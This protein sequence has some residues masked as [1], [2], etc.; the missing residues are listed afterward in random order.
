MATNDKSLHDEGLAAPDME[1]Q[2][3]FW[4]EWDVSAREGRPLN[5]ESKRRRDVVLQALRQLALISPRI[6]EVGCANGWMS[7]DLAKFGRVVATDLA[8]EAIAIAAK[9]Y[10]DIEFVTGDFQ[11]LDLGGD[12]DAV[13]CLETLSS[14]AD[15]PRFVGCLAD[16]LKP[17]GYLL[18]TTHNA[19]VYRRRTDVKPHGQGQVRKWTTR[20]ELKELFKPHFRI[21]S[22]RTVIPAGSV[23]ILRFVNS[24]KLTAL[25][26][27]IIGKQRTNSLKEAC[28]FGT[29]FFMLAQ[30]RDR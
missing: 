11:T 9:R 30:R 8:D 27:S 26:S 3:R 1:L 10:S 16:S 5:D 25:V 4:N 7:A 19:F 24:Y 21:M 15:Q 17:G 28:G 14:V 6:L 2:R 22:L 20:H 13:V 12:F 23:G 29:T 18:L